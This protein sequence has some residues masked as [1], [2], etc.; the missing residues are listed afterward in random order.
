MG[1]A[2]A[3]MGFLALVLLIIWAWVW[4][5]RRSTE[6]LHRWAQRNGYT[7]LA[8][9]RRYLRLGPYWWR[10]SKG[11]EV[12][13]VAVSDQAGQERSGYVRVGGWWWGMCSDRTDAR[14]D[15]GTHDE[16]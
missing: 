7:L 9:E 14:W 12:F 13:R 11:Q 3:V 15:D 1:E 4:H 6:L 10:K 2:L 8:S 5:F 16:G